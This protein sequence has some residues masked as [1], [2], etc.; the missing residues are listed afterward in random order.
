MNMEPTE[1]GHLTI[2][3][4]SPKGGCGKTTVAALLALRNS[5]A[6]ARFC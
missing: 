3:V 5:P 4:A 2:M 6:P 1:A